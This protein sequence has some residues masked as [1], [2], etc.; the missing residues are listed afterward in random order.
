MERIDEF[1]VDRI[2]DNSN[3]IKNLF[4]ENGYSKEFWTIK[5]QSN[6]DDIQDEFMNSILDMVTNFL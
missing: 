4:K 2:I 3:R 6:L 1:V 5:T